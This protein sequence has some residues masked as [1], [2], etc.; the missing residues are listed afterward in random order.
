[1][2]LLVNQLLERPFLH[3]R[4][5]L[6]HEYDFA[7]FNRGESMSNLNHGHVTRFDDIIRNRLLN[8]GF[9]NHIKS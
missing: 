3:Y 1:M 7:V 5:F 9:S 6:H 4:T 8:V 2:P